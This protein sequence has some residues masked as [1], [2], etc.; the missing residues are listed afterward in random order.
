MIHY[1]NLEAY[2][3]F[4]LISV[5]LITTN[6]QSVEERAFRALIRI[7]MCMHRISITIQASKGRPSTYKTNQWD[8]LETR[9]SRII[10]LLEMGGAIQV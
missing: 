10:K 4:I 6:V 1:C 7:L 9:T 8:L 5:F 2:H 3:R